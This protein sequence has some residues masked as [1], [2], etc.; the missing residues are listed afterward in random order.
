[1]KTKRVTM[2]GEVRRDIRAAI[3]EPIVTYRLKMLRKL[4]ADA[5]D[6]EMVRLEHEIFGRLGE[7]IDLTIEKPPLRNPHTPEKVRPSLKRSDAT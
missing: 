6:E 5:F 3:H 4:G 1:M 7:V 2:T